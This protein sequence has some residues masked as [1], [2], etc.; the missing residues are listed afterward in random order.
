MR[1]F[2]IYDHTEKVGEAD[3]PRNHPS[4]C[5]EE[6][7]RPGT[8]CHVESGTVV[9]RTA[10]LG[11]AETRVVAHQGVWHARGNRATAD[12]VTRAVV[13]GHRLG[14]C[15]ARLWGEG[16]NTILGRSGCG[17]VLAG[18]HSEDGVWA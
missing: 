18:A 8:P 16:R 1:G 6:A 3:V 9:P 15:V 11:R 5:A 2:R 14:H 10:R 4:G 7:P 13:R 12:G 17:E